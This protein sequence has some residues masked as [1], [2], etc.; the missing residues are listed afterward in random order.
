MIFTGKRQRADDILVKTNR[1][2]R[3]DVLRIEL[4]NFT[5]KINCIVAVAKCGDVSA[6]DSFFK[7]GFQSFGVREKIECFDVLGFLL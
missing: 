7:R 4:Q 1:Y 6:F 2:L 5:M 3:I